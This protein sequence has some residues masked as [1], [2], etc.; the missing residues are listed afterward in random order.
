MAQHRE[1]R[2]FSSGRGGHDEGGGQRW[3]P[4]EQEESQRAPG[5]W[6][7]RPV[8]RDEYRTQYAEDFERA[9]W[10]R[11]YG[12]DDEYGREAWPSEAGGY[13]DGPWSSQGGYPGRGGYS[14]GPT[15]GRFGP[16]GRYGEQGGPQWESGQGRYGQ[17]GQGQDSGYAQ[18][19]YGGAGY[20]QSGYG[21]RGFG[22][23]GYGPGG[24]GGYGREQ[25]GYGQPG[26]FGQGAGGYSM[27]EQGGQGAYGGYGQQQW[28]S[29]GGQRMRRG[30]KGYKRSDE[31]LKEDISE[32]LMQSGH[33]DPSEVTVE[34]QNGKVTLEGTVPERRMK[35][36]IEDLVDDCPGVQDIDNR[37]RVSRGE[38]GAT[39]ESGTASSGTFGAATTGSRTGKKE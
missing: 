25:S 30:P 39:S 22:H 18:G 4:G 20:G 19:S 14:A 2:S 11:G 34:V 17:G 37:V 10:Q 15:G 23:G 3:R 24:Y 6:R 29:P 32:R 33:I 16:R 12:Q 28:G 27:G 9:Q 31:R 21:Q 26:G 7:E 8:S 38:S 1:N 35:H 5:E 36:Q 13:Q